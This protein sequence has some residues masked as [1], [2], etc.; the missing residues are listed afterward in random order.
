MAL[1]NETSRAHELHVELIA[2]S[3][4]TLR[5][6]L[7][8]ALRDACRDGRLAHGATLPSS[9]DLARQLGVSRGVVNDAYGQ[10]SAEGYIE[11][12]PRYA[13]TVRQAA[14]AHASAPEPPLPAVARHGDEH[15]RYDLTALTPDVST[16]PRAAWAA[17][18]RRALQTLPDR[19]LDYSDPRGPLGVRVALA[20]Y[21]SRTRACVTDPARIV[22]CSGVT[23][24]VFLACTVLRQRGLT[25]IAVEDPSNT[26][27][28]K[29]VR[30]AGLELVPIPVDEDG[31]R[32]Q[33]LSTA[34]VRAVLVAPAHQFPTGAA[35][36][37]DRRQALIT[38]ATDR[39]GL[40]IEDD[41]DAEYRYDA[42][43]VG[44]LQGR[45][46]EAVIY[47]GSASKT[48]AP[49]LR[50]GWLHLPAHLLE[51]TVDAIWGCAGEPSPIMLTAFADLLER[52]EVDRHLR[53]NR[54]I[55]AAR[56]RRLIHALARALPDITVDGI[57]AGLHAC[58][59]LPAEI[60]PATV[61][62]DLATRGVLA[63]T[64][65]EYAID[66]AHAQ[67]GLVLGYSR[68]AEHDTDSVVD[69]LA[70]VIATSRRATHSPDQPAGAQ[71]RQ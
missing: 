67:H 1:N 15:W 37:P 7:A 50:V 36:S 42:S 10:L 61:T 30:A 5:R 33:D 62:H 13:P 27:L 47:T 49:A 43:P 2:G 46:P 59:R 32:V 57:A 69:L 55:Y 25:R 28:L 11:Q 16:F 35:L 34:D 18:F 52:G 21:L 31:L 17:A 14:P 3:G 22:M 64:L 68:L 54:T 29:N 20:A 66:R 38:W 56:R 53:R 23:H 24:G 41:Y 4:R 63:E 40:I 9:R 58:L 51:A 39:D 70:E 71:T 60:P 48:L 8:D 44:S 26:E 65:A 12:R 6:Q 45:Y 19:A